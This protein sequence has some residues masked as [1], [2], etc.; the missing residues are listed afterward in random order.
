[1]VV[2]GV[3]VVLNLLLLVDLE[4]VVLIFCSNLTGN[5]I[6]V[7]SLSSCGARFCLFGHNLLIE[8]EVLIL[9]TVDA[10]ALFR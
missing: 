9:E 7:V 10:I 5:I 2:P 1:M 3:L 6:L 4:F 8:Y